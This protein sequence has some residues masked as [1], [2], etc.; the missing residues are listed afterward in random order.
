MINLQHN[1]KKNTMGRNLS[2]K[3]VVIFG[4]T[5]FIGSHLVKNLCKEACQINII[6]RSPKSSRSFFFANDPGQIEVTNIN[7]YTQDNINLVTQNCD[8]IFNLIGILAESQKYKFEFVH[9]KIPEMIANAAKNNKIR[10][11]VHISALNVDRI[12]NSKYAIS[13]NLGEKKINEVFPN[14]VIVRPGVVFGKGDNFTNFFSALS[15]FSPF[16]P[17]IGTPKIDFSNGLMRILDFSK[18]VKFQPLYVG[19]L[20]KFLLNICLKKNKVYD[21]AGPFIKSFSEIYD[22]ILNHKQRRRIYLPLPF[23]Q[24]KILAFFFELLPNPLLTRDQINLLK[25]DSVSHKGLTNLLKVVD[26]PA[27]METII[28]TYL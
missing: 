25:Y 4:G 9:S 2:G 6:S 14:A 26:N 19:D 8:V 22:I 28:K 7:E 18:K 3:K 16:L 5:G 11:L 1:Y 20:V 13:K 24:A 27:S 10:N 15:R 12:K 17:L 23:F 21:L